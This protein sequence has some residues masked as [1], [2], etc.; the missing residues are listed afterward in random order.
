MK[1][2]S[3]ESGIHL[4]CDVLKPNVIPKSTPDLQVKIGSEP[5]GMFPMLPNWISNVYVDCVVDFVQTQDSTTMDWWRDYFWILLAGAIIIVSVSLGLILFCACRRHLRQGNKLE[6]AKPL[7]QNQRDEENMY[8]NVLNEPTQLPPLPPRSLPSSEAYSPQ[9]TP[10]GP[11]ATYSSLHKIRNTKT[12]S[13]PSYVE[14]ENDYDD[15]E[16]PT[17]IGNGH[18]ETM[19]SSF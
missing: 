10:H 5:C 3:Q 7:K 12:V 13:I 9:E 4:E 15:V 8:E 6:I 14:L 18:F 19:I 17:A 2:S 16:M 1:C 11:E